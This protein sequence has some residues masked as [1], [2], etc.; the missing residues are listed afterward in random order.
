ME[1]QTEEKMEVIEF[2]PA[3]LEYNSLNHEDSF[4]Y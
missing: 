3:F 2:T 1:K 4:R